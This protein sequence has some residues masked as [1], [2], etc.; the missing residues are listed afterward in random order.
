MR[1]LII[2]TAI[3]LTF[4][5]SANAQISLGTGTHTN[6]G[7]GAG[8]STVR[9]DG[10]STVRT[11]GDGTTTI[12]RPAHDAVDNTRLGTEVNV[13]AGIKNSSTQNARENNSNNNADVNASADAHSRAIINPAAGSPTTRVHDNATGITRSVTRTTNGVMGSVTDTIQ[14]PLSGGATVNS[15]TTG[16]VND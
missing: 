16:S 11:F 3:A 4:A 10:N 15:T 1:K 7:I 5:A 8:P 6:L 2:T 13:G 12:T 9:V 14:G